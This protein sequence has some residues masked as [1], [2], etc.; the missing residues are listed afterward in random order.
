MP[1]GTLVAGITSGA[2]EVALPPRRD[3][4]ELAVAATRAVGMDITGVDVLEAADGTL[5][6]LEVNA[7]FGFYPRNSE[8]VDALVE[9]VVA[10]GKTPPA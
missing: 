3:L 6:A 2:E 9:Q 7:N 8:I 5:Y 4:D 10:R 1:R